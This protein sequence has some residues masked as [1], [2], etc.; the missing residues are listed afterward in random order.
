MV[1]SPLRGGLERLSHSQLAE[2]KS[3]DEAARRAGGSIAV[4][5]FFCSLLEMI[6]QFVKKWAKKFSNWELQIQSFNSSC[7]LLKTRAIALR[8]GGQKAQMLSL[9]AQ[10]K[11]SNE[12]TG[13]AGGSIA[14]AAGSSTES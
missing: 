9:Q 2:E 14:L 6:C 8:Q 10:G 12:A 3:D 4:N 5:K 13:R 11:S 1:Q 7:C